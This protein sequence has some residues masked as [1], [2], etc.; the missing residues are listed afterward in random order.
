[1]ANTLVVGAQWGDE[2]K[3]KI[4]DILT[5]NSD[6]ICRYQGGP[7]AGHTVVLKDKKFIFHLIP[8]GIL[9]SNKLCIIGN[10]VV[11]DPQAMVLEMEDLKKGGVKIGKNLKVSKN[12]HLIMP[13]HKV[14]DKERETKLGKGK[15]GTTMRGVGPAYIDKIG[16]VGIRICDLMNEKIFREKLN[17][18]RDEVVGKLK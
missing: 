12:A 9:H 17:K 13:Y 3:G 1:M 7:N 6:I 15:I 8:S 4:V 5:E 10:G 16:R 18:L 2:G 14:L 11:I